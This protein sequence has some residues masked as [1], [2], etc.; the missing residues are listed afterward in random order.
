M[1]WERLSRSLRITGVLF[2]IIS[3]FLEPHVVYGMLGV[4]FFVV[5]TL[6]KKKGR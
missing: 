3:F 1:L 4:T 2:I 5:G 6:Q